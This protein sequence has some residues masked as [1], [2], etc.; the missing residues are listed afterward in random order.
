MVLGWF[1]RLAVRSVNRP[2]RSLSFDPLEQRCLLAIDTQFAD[3]KLA[4]VATAQDSIVVTSDQGY[5]RINGQEPSSGPI[6]ASAVTEIDAQ[7]GLL[8]TT[9]LSGVNRDSFPN[10]QL[11]IVRT[12]RHVDAAVVDRYGS[13]LI[14]PQWQDV[15]GMSASDVL[16]SLSDG[17]WQELVADSELPNIAAI[18]GA[19]RAQQ[20]VDTLLQSTGLPTL[21]VGSYEQLF[22]SAV[23][24]Q[25]RIMGPIAPRWLLGN[26]I[27]ASDAPLAGFGD[28]LQSVEAFSELLPQFASALDSAE[29]DQLVTDSAIGILSGDGDGSSLGGPMMMAAAAVP[30]PSDGIEGGPISINDVTV[31][32]GDVAIFTVNL[33]A[34]FTDGVEFDWSTLDGDIPAGQTR[35]YTPATGHMTFADG[36]EGTSQEIHV[37]T[38][39]ISPSDPVEADQTFHVHLSNL[40][41]FDGHEGPSYFAKDDGIGTIR[42]PRL[43]PT[44]TFT[45]GDVEVDEH[46]GYA[47]V[48]IMLSGIPGQAVTVDWKTHD[49]TANVDFDYQD[50]G[51]TL[52]FPALTTTLTQYVE[53]PIL[54]DEVFEGSDYLTVQLSDPVSA[55]IDYSHWYGKVTIN[56]DD[57]IPHLN[58]NDVVVYKS[59]GTAVLTISITNPS[60]AYDIQGTVT[61][62][63]G[64]ATSPADFT[65]L[66]NV[67]FTIPRGDTST[68]V[69]IPLHVDPTD[70][71]RES[72]TATIGNANT[73]GDKTTS[74]VTILPTSESRPVVSIGNGTLVDDGFVVF[75]LTLSGALNYDLVVPYATSDGSAISPDDY[76]GTASTVTI[77]AG[78]TSW[79]ILVPA[80]RTNWGTTAKSFYVDIGASDGVI[81]GTQQAIGTIPPDLDIPNVSI[82]DV[83]VHEGETAHF[84]VRLSHPSPNPISY[85]WYSQGY[86]YG[87]ES[88]GPKRDFES[89]PYNIHATVTFQP[90]QTERTIDVPTLT[91]ST[92]EADD[93][94]FLALL[95]PNDGTSVTTTLCVILDNDP[96]SVAISD[97][98]TPQ[99][100]YYSDHFVFQVPI[101]LSAPIGRQVRVTWMTED[102]SATSPN[103][104]IASSGEIVF[105]ETSPLT[106][107]AIIPSRYIGL[108][109]VDKTFRVNITSVSGATIGNAS[110]IVTIH[111]GGQPQI[112]F[113][114]PS[115]NTRQTAGYFDITLALP[116]SPVLPSDD[117]AI[118][119]DYQTSDGS[120]HAGVDYTASQ[121][122]LTFGPGQ[123]TKVVRI[124]IVDRGLAGSTDRNFIVTFSNPHN[125][126]LAVPQVPVNCTIVGG[127]A[128][129][130]AS[131]QSDKQSVH[132]YDY[133]QDTPD[134]T[135]HVPSVSNYLAMLRATG[136][137]QV[138]LSATDGSSTI[139]ANR[140]YPAQDFP[141][142][143][144][145]SS[146]R[147]G[148]AIFDVIVSEFINFGFY[149]LPILVSQTAPIQVVANRLS[150]GLTS[151]ADH[152]G[153]TDATDHDIL[154]ARP[155]ALVDGDDL[156]EI[157]VPPITNPENMALNGFTL[158]IASDDPNSR[159]WTT[160]DRTTEVP[161][162]YRIGIDNLPVRVFADPIGFQ[163]T[164]ISAVLRSRA[165]EEVA[166]AQIF[167]TPVSGNLQAFHPRSPG[168]H[169]EDFPVPDD[170][171][172]TPGVGIRINGDNAYTNSLRMRIRVTPIAGVEYVLRRNND[173]LN[174]Y[175][176]W[177]DDGPIDDQFSRALLHEDNEGVVPART[178]VQDGGLP[179]SWDVEWRDGDLAIQEASLEL[180]AR[181][182]RTGAE[183]V[184]DTIT[185]HPYFS[186]VIAMGGWKQQPVITRGDLE[187]HIE[188]PNHGTFINALQ[189]YEAGYNVYMYK[190]SDAIYSYAGSSSSA[191]SFG[192]AYDAVVQSIRGSHI[193]DVAI[194]GYSRG[195]GAVYDLAWLLNTR[196]SSIGTFQI[197]FAGY[198]D[199]VGSY[200]LGQEN[201]RPPSADYVL[202]V[203]QEADADDTFRLDGGAMNDPNSFDEEVNVETDLTPTAPNTRFTH[204]NIDDDPAVL[205]LIRNRLRARILPWVTF[206]R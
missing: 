115:T 64:T 113:S 96:V 59:A 149:M 57:A 140:W 110:A 128:T 12:D 36:Q 157:N 166:R 85:W 173:I 108:G 9:D 103:E 160:R 165:G 3:G 20:V 117:M 136:N 92:P 61:T 151:D 18:L 79:V 190:E 124:P 148:I 34:D 145:V 196:R 7:R 91:D 28:A 78:N 202:N 177:G 86:G 66:T 37:Y 44:P 74:T 168:I 70:T 194:F 112:T 164:D 132:T 5:V 27:D 41:N 53:V 33:D 179:W 142:H 62:H 186:V 6:A 75:P 182:T 187:P 206:G 153:D 51:G 198:I 32:D 82:D 2:P 4:I 181:D 175:S 48:P 154:A 76:I 205:A 65:A 49:G 141:T 192:L 162:S 200:S 88:S 122:T 172:E 123:A 55:Q 93:E 119:V 43:T 94:F 130:T 1:R 90:G 150:V 161:A 60:D 13:A 197:V 80:A 73:Y 99:A 95:N 158:S 125:A 68:T 191:G 11:A 63:D 46:I 137:D 116:S 42:D 52:T 104:Y 14:G 185:F 159:L 174:V 139:L 146:T 118:T 156:V 19:E 87:S 201:R 101:Q 189:L 133:G 84:I 24:L 98:T 193:R 47:L 100:P 69:S 138:S 89:T 15:A 17:E 180:V 144:R 72:F 121:G 81:I 8:S 35:H 114:M 147:T 97:V 163:T 106:Q 38:T 204:Y 10:I 131:L 109:H 45:A 176:V 152:D 184:V 129:G 107:Y 120:A 40:V 199:A 143:V 170:Q 67:P 71:G 39:G 31:A 105:G 167:L 111:D 29:I 16:E 126:T 83:L 183:V 50:V 54:D 21:S 23:T 127:Q 178:S 77:P 155:G 188:D 169:D 134:L 22:G 102:I 135:I 25:S 203:Y 30:S 171:E 26:S 56:D 58:I 195:G